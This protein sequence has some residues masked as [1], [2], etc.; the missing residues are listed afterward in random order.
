[1]KKATI[2]QINKLK[3]LQSKTSLIQDNSQ[4][5]AMFSHFL[6]ILKDIDFLSQFSS[7]FGTKLIRFDYNS[8]KTYI[9]SELK[10]LMKSSI[11]YYQDNLNN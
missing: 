3:E 7:D 2:N 8:D 9:T 10:E 5:R 4:L 6:Q 11:E 1:M